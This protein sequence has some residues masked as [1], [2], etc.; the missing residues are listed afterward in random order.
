M[1]KGIA[2]TDLGSVLIGDV[3]DLD[4]LVV[5]EEPHHPSGGHWSVEPSGMAQMNGETGVAVVLRAGAA[6]F[7]YFPAGGDRQQRT[8]LDVGAETPSKLTMAKTELLTRRPT[9]QFLP[10]VVGRAGDDGF[11]PESNFHAV[12]T[13]KE[14][15]VD[16]DASEPIIQSD[17]F[18]C[19]ARF[20]SAEN[21]LDDFFRI[22]AVF[23]FKMRSVQS[24]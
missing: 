13:K 12:A 2:P 1:G 7:S 22:D 17:L 16:A 10:F 14:G 20:L 4:N 15:E 19:H 3:I 24:V 8:T 21:K 11:K 23:N 9:E 18:E 6:R 5:S